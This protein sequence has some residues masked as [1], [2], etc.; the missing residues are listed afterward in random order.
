ML[1]LFKLNKDCVRASIQGF[2][3]KAGPADFSQWASNFFPACEKFQN[4]LEKYLD[5]Y[6]LKWCSLH[7]R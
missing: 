3:F 5:F 1:L 7:F 6:V 4:N 2:S